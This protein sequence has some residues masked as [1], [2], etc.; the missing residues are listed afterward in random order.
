MG[1]HGG[2][3]RVA[4]RIG[5]VVVSDLLAEQDQPGSRVA[6]H[7]AEAEQ[8]RHNDDA[9]DIDQRGVAVGVGLAK[10]YPRA[11]QRRS[12]GLT[13]RPSGLAA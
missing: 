7:E 3:H 2:G 12:A 11:S 6:H 13:C 1:V 9:G 8:H 4:E 10:T 5:G